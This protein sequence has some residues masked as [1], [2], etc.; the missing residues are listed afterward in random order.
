MS[1]IPS[2]APQ[3]VPFS[4][5]DDFHNAVR[6]HLAQDIDTLFAYAKLPSPLNDACRYVM[7]GQGKLVRPLLVASSFANIYEGGTKDDENVVGAD[8]INIDSMDGGLA[9]DDSK[10]SGLE[11]ILDYDS[12]YDMCRRAALA[13]EL[14]HTYSLV[15]DDLPCM[16]D[17]ELRRGQPT[18]HIVFDEA[19]ALLAGDVLQTL[20]FEVLSAE[21]P[22]FA[23]F[24]ATLASMISAVFAPRAR[25]MVSGQMLDLN[26]EARASI[27]QSELE[28]I[29]RDKTGALIEAAMLMGG[30]CA[31]ATAQERMALQ[32]CA[33]HIGLAFQV[34]D[35]ILDVTGNTND[36]GKP[37]G[38]DEKLDKSTYVKLMGVDAAKDYA[39]SLFDNGRSAIT[40]ELIDDNSNALLALIEWLWAR[41]K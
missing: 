4:N 19:T 39:Q 7:T 8:L 41:K 18:A 31:G 34:Q 20:A 3:F 36:L 22:T 37:A 10:N 24:D 27:T 35:D 17:D 13:V 1:S 14:L 21:I 23:P 6:A 16:D 40:R 15:H 30:I 11:N 26:A 25:R 33:Q 2:L 28:A 32:D 9:S 5:F 12:R 38:S 29:H